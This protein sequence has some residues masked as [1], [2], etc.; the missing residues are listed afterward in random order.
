MSIPSPDPS[1]LRRRVIQERRAPRGAPGSLRWL[2][3]VLRRPVRVERCG[4]QVHFVLEERRRPLHVQE[5][6]ALEALSSE[7]R[8]RLMSHEHPQPAERIQYLVAV[9][10]ALASRGWRGVEALPSRVLRKA[11]AQA[12]VLLQQELSETL[13]DLAERLGAMRGAAEAREDRI[14]QSRA[15]DLNTSVVISET[16]EAEFEALQ[17]SW[18]GTVPQDL[19][20]PI[21]F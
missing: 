10:E 6:E 3:S 19:G 4:M 7:L 17:R 1:P 14:K 16:S 11:Q 8:A 21:R 9:H 2:K 13:E 20:P 15:A 12:R 18:T 5:A